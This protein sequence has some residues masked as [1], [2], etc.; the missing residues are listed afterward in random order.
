MSTLGVIP[1]SAA[2]DAGPPLALEPVLGVPILL[3][4]AHNLLRVL[5][6]ADLRVLTDREDVAELARMHGV[7]TLAHDEEIDLQRALIHDPA[8]FF[9]SA[10]TVQA[11]IA[12]GRREL[13]T[14]QRT[15][16][17]RLRADREEDLELMRAVAAGLAHD[18]PCIAGVRRMR[19]GLPNLSRAFQAI[20]TDVDGVL[21][22]GTITLSASGEESRRFHMHDGMGG[23][24]LRDAGYEIGWLSA[25]ASSGAAGRRAEML[26]V[27]HVDIGKGDKGPRFERLC[28]QMKIAPENTIY[29]GDDVNDLPALARAGLGVCPCDARPE[30]IAAADLVLES[31]GG[32][33]AFR[34]LADILLASGDGS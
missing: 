27:K 29:L 9:C 2:A 13:V 15:A 20:I 30:V 25:F 31:P 3:W 22:D 4:A 34:E 1:V 14:A 21:T 33:G 10:E 26:G 19:L 18:H 6:A 32:G 12:Q 24:R 17:E 7:S 28:A 11:A 8:Q 23:A 16:I 5:D